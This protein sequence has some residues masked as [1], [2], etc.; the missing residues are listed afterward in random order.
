MKNIKILCI[1]NELGTITKYIA[2]RYS[3]ISKILKGSLEKLKKA[4]EDTYY[5]YEVE[6][7]GRNLISVGNS[8]I[9]YI[10]HLEKY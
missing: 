3:K 9:M 10:R 2:D 6:D 1:S 4:D 7:V 8:L 5:S